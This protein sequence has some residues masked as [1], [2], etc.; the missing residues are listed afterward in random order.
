MADALRARGVERPAAILAAHT[1][2]AAFMPATRGQ[3]RQ[4]SHLLRP[5]DQQGGKTVSRTVRAGDLA[6][7]QPF[8]SLPFR[9]WRGHPLPSAAP[10]SSRSINVELAALM[11]TTSI[12]TPW[13]LNLCTT[14]S[15]A[16]TAV[17]SQKCDCD[18]SMSTPMPVA[19]RTSNASTKM[20]AEAKNTWPETR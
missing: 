17:T 1:G 18:T 8:E 12:A 20:S 2:M 7:A 15:S 13:A 3:L 10:A 19:S 5:R 6:Y 4:I 11:P 14:L 9:P 16:A